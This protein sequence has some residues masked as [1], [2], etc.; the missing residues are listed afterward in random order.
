MSIVHT[1]LPD[2]QAR[3]SPLDRCSAR[4]TCSARSSGSELL[5]NSLSQNP[6]TAPRF[7]SDRMYRYSAVR[8]TPRS[9]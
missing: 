1:C 9:E 4:A 7:R 6:V 2:T 5:T 8:P 3:W